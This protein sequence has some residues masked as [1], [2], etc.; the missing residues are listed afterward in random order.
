MPSAEGETLARTQ[1]AIDAAAEH[2][3]AA[4][5]ALARAEVK[6]AAETYGTA[7]WASDVETLR[8]LFHE[9]ANLYGLGP[10]GLIEWPREDWLKRV[11]S[12]PSGTGDAPFEI[13]S[14]DA[15]GPEMASVKID[16]AVGSGQRFTDYLNFLKIGG[17]WR[18]IAKIFH[19]HQ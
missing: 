19:A 4:E 11:A 15:A 10:D 17:D 2:A 3:G 18:V 7:L 13:L 16:C 1:A 8:R 5:L 14:V 9:R 12:R 6:A